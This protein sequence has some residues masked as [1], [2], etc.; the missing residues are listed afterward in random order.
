[1]PSFHEARIIAGGSKIPEYKLAAP[2][3]ETMIHSLA[4]RARKTH[5]LIA[6][7]MGVTL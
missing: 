6:Q 2:A 4:S 5:P 3:S 1:M 7:A